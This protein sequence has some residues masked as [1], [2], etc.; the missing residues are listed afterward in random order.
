MND[1]PRATTSFE[2]V[3]RQS[4]IY[5]AWCLIVISVVALGLLLVRAVFTR[6]IPGET[7]PW[8]ALLGIVVTILYE[9][10]CIAYVRSRARRGM[11]ISSALPYENAVVE[12]AIPTIAIA[13][14]WR[15]AVLPT[16]EALASP[17]LFIYTAFILLSVLHLSPRLSLVS[18]VLCAAQHAALVTYAVMTDQLNP[19]HGYLSEVFLYSLSGGLLLNGLAASFVARRVAAHVHTQLDETEQREDMEQEMDIAS[20]VQRNL[21]PRDEPEIDGFHIAGWNRPADQTGG[22]YYDWQP[23]PDGAVAVSVADVTGHGLGPALVTA[24]CRAY[25]RATLRPGLGLHDVVTRINALL[26]E[27]L[28]ADRFITFVIALLTPGTGEVR[29]VSAGHGPILVYRHASA[30]VE[31]RKADGV[32]L[33]ILPDT[34]FHEIEPLTLAKGDALVFVTDGF[35]EWANTEGEEFGV[36]RLKRSITTAAKRSTDAATLIASVRR[37]VEHFTRGTTQP[38]DLTILVA[39]R[40]ENQS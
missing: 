10:V 6:D 16:D 30:S 12:S 19:E 22:D 24:F 14:I 4:E 7:L 27:D 11:P 37:D 31:E 8:I 29:L 28:P 23:L 32:P 35:F 2:R 36:E 25:A 39:R 20:R 3:V 15:H 33:G 18:G 38:D 13:L 9:L 5:R 21:L 34:A 17:A 1:A 40:T 26:A